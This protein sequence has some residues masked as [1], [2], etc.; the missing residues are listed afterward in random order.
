MTDYFSLFS[1]V[2]PAKRWDS[3]STNRKAQQPRNS[4]LLFSVRKTSNC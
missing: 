2:C 4:R 3:S 1:S